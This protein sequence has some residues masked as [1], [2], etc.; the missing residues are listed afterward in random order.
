MYK[1]LHVHIL[2]IFKEDGKIDLESEFQTNLAH[3]E[4]V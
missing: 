2:D 4:N 1:N 3:R